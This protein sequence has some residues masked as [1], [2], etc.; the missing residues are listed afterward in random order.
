MEY[1]IN[2]LSTSPVLVTP[3][4][5]KLIRKFISSDDIRHYVRKKGATV[6][7]CHVMMDR[8]CCAL[9]AS[10]SACNI[11]PRRDVVGMFQKLFDGWLTMLHNNNFDDMPSD[12]DGVIVRTRESLKEQLTYD[13]GDRHKR[14]LEMEY[15]KYHDHHKT[16]EELLELL[17]THVFRTASRYYHVPYHESVDTQERYRSLRCDIITSWCLSVP[18]DMIAK[19]RPDDVF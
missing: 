9:F 5:N 10:S 3:V 12:I 1:S 13:L 11:T 16:K 19:V 8:M 6:P 17:S 4:S 7:P 18:H 2:D 15:A 14:K